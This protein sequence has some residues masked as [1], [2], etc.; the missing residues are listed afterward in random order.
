MKFNMVSEKSS[1]VKSWL[2]HFTRKK[3]HTLFLES[4]SLIVSNMRTVAELYLDYP[5]FSLTLGPTNWCRKIKG[6][7]VLLGFIPSMEPVQV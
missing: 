4:L 5:T 7:F 6:L 1:W 2:S 3:S